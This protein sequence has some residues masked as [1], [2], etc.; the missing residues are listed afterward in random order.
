M[1][2]RMCLITLAFAVLLAGC[3][4]PVAV[5]APG[6]MPAVEAGEDAF[7]QFERELENLRQQLK[8]PGLS[9][10]I[11]KDQELVWAKGFGYADLENR[12]EATADTPYRLA[13]V[14]KPIA[15][16]LIMQ[17][18]EEGVLDL[19]D[20]VS[21]YGVEM[22]SEGVV[23]VWH[24]L[25]HT[26]EG[27]PGTR[28]NYRGDLYA[29]LGQVIEGASGQSFGDLLSERILEPLDMTHSAPNYT[30]CALAAFIASPDTSERYQNHT[31]VNR[32][33]ARPYQLDPSYNIVEGAYP[34][35][36]NP[37]AGLISSVVD[38]AKFDIALDNNVLLRE[39]TVEKMFEPVFS[40]CEDRTD[41]MYGLGWYAQQYRDTRLVWHAGRQPP[42]VSS[43]YLKVPDEDVTFIILANTT[44]LNTPHPFGYGDALYSTPALAFYKA[45]VFSQQR[46]R[47]VPHVDWAAEKPELVAQ[48]NLVTD[49]D[50][51]EVLERDLWS[52]RQ[53]FA[54]VG[55]PALARRLNDVYRQVYGASNAQTL[56]LYTFAGVDYYPIVQAQMELSDAELARLAGSYFLSEAPAVEGA[57]MPAEVR[58][59]IHEGKLIGFDEAAAPTRGC[60][61]LVPLTSTRFAISENPGLS[62]EFHLDGD[63][64]GTVTVEAAGMAAVY[65]PVQ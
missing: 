60:L 32:A 8:I 58:M 6:S 22:E 43:L 26:S 16:T 14:T 61:T 39:E 12:V 3:A 53:L 37:G 36:F 20:P 9:A 56:D 44:N 7:A 30:E 17:L 33:V 11:V 25:T 52:H 34:A 54:S 24:L 27:V 31:R 40:T 59:E 50:V 13:S 62:V 65:R 29:R 5:P 35:W 4:Q 41:L 51:R 18:V 21:E 48:L 47:T 57:G 15:A 45:F 23:R 55:H 1:E 49:E 19:D 28:H 38:L 10:A 2:R 64:V 42:S 63:K 46:G